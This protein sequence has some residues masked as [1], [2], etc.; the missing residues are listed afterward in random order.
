ML[1]KNPNAPLTPE[2]YKCGYLNAK[3]HTFYKCHI[4]GTCPAI[5][6]K[7]SEN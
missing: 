1:I 6:P 7:K 3:L 4:P 2:C 5:E